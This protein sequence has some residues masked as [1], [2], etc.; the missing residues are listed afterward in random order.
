MAKKIY[1]RWQA[2]TIT[3]ALKTRRVV[4]VSGPRQ[5]GKTTLVKQMVQSNDT[6]LTLDDDALL[7]TASSDPLGFAKHHRGAST[8]A[9]VIDEVQKVPALI[10]AIKRVVDEDSSPGQFL[11]TGSSDFQKNPEITESL[12]GRVKNIELR[13]LSIGETLERNPSFLDRA[14]GEGWPAQIK[15]YDKKRV[16]EL[17][18]IGGYPE[19]LFFNA[20]ERT[21]WHLDY[22]RTLLARDLRDVAN[23]RRKETL[24]ELLGVL[25]AWSSKY[26]DTDSICA[27]LNITKPT[28]SSYINA[29]AALYLFQKVPSWRKTDYDRVGKRDKFFTTDT[30][31]MASLL[32]WR[33]DDVFL[34]SDRSGKIFETLVYNQLFSETSLGYEY[35]LFHYRDRAKREIDFIVENRQGAILGIEVKAGSMVSQSDCKHLNWFKGNVKKP[36]RGIV[37]YS[38]ENT[39][40]LAKDILAVPIAAL[41]N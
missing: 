6:F 29:L 24:R 37:L 34:D 8:G 36:F 3:Q 9:T 19:P 15:G 20:H 5:C 35:S 4:M 10:T 23:I 17:A 33:L 16:I 22:A 27:K 13:P 26:L 31:L 14:F 28:L 21:G 32:D 25:A 7:K 40:P 41:W 12:A 30:G 1:P 38:G 39:L 11:L 2:N 18:F